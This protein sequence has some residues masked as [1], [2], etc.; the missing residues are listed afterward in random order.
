[1]WKKDKFFHEEGKNLSFFDRHV[2]ERSCQL[3]VL[4]VEKYVSEINS[5]SHK[6]PGV[7]PGLQ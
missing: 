2:F 1:M 7:H 5:S 6:L 3:Q 4:Y